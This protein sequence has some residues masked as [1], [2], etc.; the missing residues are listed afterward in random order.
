MSV[1]FGTQ[2]QKGKTS[3]KQEP[4]APTIPALTDYLGE[5]SGL[6]TSGPTGTQLSAVND[7]Q[8][9]YGEGNQFAGQLTGL[10]NDLF[11]G[12]DSQSG[13]AGDAYA[14]LQR[15]LSPYA[16]GQ[17]TDF[18]SNPY[19]QQML[20][21]VGGSVQER[22]NAQFAGAGRDLSGRVCS[23]SPVIRSMQVPSRMGWTRPA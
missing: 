9:I 23:T 10:A 20:S 8:D 1:S 4:W 7:L 21:T 16:E 14:T 19:L 22:I 5:V 15:Q 18:D 11:T 6:D 13:M 17:Y 2:K 3:Q 12:V